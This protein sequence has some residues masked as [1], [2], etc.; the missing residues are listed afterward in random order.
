MTMSLPESW[1]FELFWKIFFD[2]ACR[3]SKG[4]GLGLGF[5]LGDLSR[6]KHM[7]Y[8]GDLM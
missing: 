2:V 4:K 5:S 3:K 7:P 8:I 1:I 6:G